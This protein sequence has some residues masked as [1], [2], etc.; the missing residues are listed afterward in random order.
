M[1]QATAIF[2]R[3]AELGDPI[4]NVEVKGGTKEELLENAWSRC[5]DG[6]YLERLLSPLTAE[7]WWEKN[8]GWKAEPSL[9]G[10]DQVAFI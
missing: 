6:F 5:V 4:K 9:V 2:R 1:L 7:I 8:E 10:D 3:P